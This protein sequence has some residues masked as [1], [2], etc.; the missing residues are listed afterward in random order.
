MT[1][2]FK[3]AKGWRI[4]TYLLCPPMIGLFSWLLWVGFHSAN[5]WMLLLWIP[6]SVG[7]IALFVYA[8]IDAGK[9]AVILTREFI[10]Q[11][12]VFYERKIFLDQIKGFRLTEHYL[13]FEPAGNGKKIRVSRYYEGFQ[14]LAN[15]AFDNYVNLDYAAKV[16]SEI[17]ILSN[18]ELGLTPDQRE[19]MLASARRVC[20]YLN[21]GVW[22]LVIWILFFPKPYE[23]V[24][25][26][27]VIF[28]LMLIG[29][30][31]RYRGIIQYD[32]DE[33]SAYPSVA[34]AMILTS[35]SFLLRV[36]FDYNLLEYAVLWNTI[37]PL[38]VLLTVVYVLPMNVKINS[39]KRVFLLTMVTLFMLCY[40][41]G[42]YV[43][44][45]C[46]LDSSETVYT[47]T[48]AGKRISKGKTTT[49]YLE[50][51]PWG[52]RKEIEDVKVSREHY[53][54]VDIGD[55]TEVTQHQGA[56]GTPWI[57]VK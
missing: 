32:D 39:I 29:V 35:L 28:P 55:E 49:Y 3:L 5:Y 2:V 48:I 37:I 46:L 52:D 40:S 25:T 22:I 47:T 24:I 42:T 4:F 17:E 31:Y 41:F 9:G 1:R 16:K 18:E 44:I 34:F 10:I 43:S 51:N 45:N 56:L 13:I 7:M 26:V 30:G 54:S 27:A 12:D 50:L 57:L 6:L 19:N 21:N 20:K 8:L 33:K 11:R 23:V 15:W 14:L 38:S 53:E 36:M